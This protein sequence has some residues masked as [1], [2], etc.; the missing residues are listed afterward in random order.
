MDKLNRPNIFAFTVT[1][2]AKE[3][4]RPNKQRKAVLIFNNGATPVEL[5]SSRKQTYG[6]GMP[7]PSNSSYT[8]EHF[9]PQGQYWVICS[10]GT[11]DLRV[12]EDIQDA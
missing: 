7:I 6:Q 2:T 5:L 9:N 10:A 4:L 1:T 8:S 12:E 3:L 11:I